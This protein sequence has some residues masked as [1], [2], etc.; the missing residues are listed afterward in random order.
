M[1]EKIKSFKSLLIG[2]VVVI[3]LAIMIFKKQTYL[4]LKN[5]DFVVEYG[6]HISMDIQDYLDFSECTEIQ[7]REIIDSAKLNLDISHEQDKDYPAIGSYYAD[8]SYNKED[9]QFHIIV[10]DTI[11]PEF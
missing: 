7:K 6:G 4:Q 3:V 2:I 1:W 11:A 9:V 8:I 10:K 5:T